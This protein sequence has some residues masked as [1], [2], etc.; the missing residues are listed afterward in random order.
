M[1]VQLLQPDPI[2]RDDP[3]R[4]KISPQHKVCPGRNVYMWI[5]GKEIGAIVCTANRYG[6]PKTERDLSSVDRYQEDG[7]KMILYSIWSYK[8]GCGQ[9]LVASLLKKEYRMLKDG[10]FRI[11]TLSPKTE[12]ARNFHLKNG[13]KLLQTNRTTVNYEY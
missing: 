11:I 7:F 10:R 8:K 6:I 3:V 4:P 12:M 5:E 13:A 9:K 1:L 2:L